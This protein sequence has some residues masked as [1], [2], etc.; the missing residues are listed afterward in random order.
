MVA[1]GTCEVE[2]EEEKEEEEK[3]NEE[4][5]EEVMVMIRNQRHVSIQSDNGVVAANMLGCI[6][7]SI[8][9]TDQTI[10]IPLILEK[11]VCIS[12]G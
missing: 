1:K 12:Q 11:Q 2:E 4:E 9:L 7:I 10:F 3:G 8:L 6:Q 5:E